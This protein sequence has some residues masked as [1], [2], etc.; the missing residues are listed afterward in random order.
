[1]K[2]VYNPRPGYNFYVPSVWTLTNHQ[3]GD[4]V[5]PMIGDMVMVWD[6]QHHELRAH[7]SLPDNMELMFVSRT[8][9]GQGKIFEI[10]KRDVDIPVFG[11]DSCVTINPNSGFIVKSGKPANDMYHCIKFWC[12]TE[13]LS[14]QCEKVLDA[15][16]ENNGGRYLGII[17][18]N[19][20]LWGP[21]TYPSHRSDFSDSRDVVYL[22]TEDMAG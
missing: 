16:V 11:T 2:L 1:M 5:D 18:S 13:G 9:D 17:D 12:A 21:H 14:I 7:K 6:D 3:V 22:W 20:W 15:E 19:D 10:V 8:D 4:T